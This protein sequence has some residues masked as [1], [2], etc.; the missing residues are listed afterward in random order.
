MTYLAAIVTMACFGLALRVSGVVPA[1]ARAVATSRSAAKLMRDS[2]LNESE[3]E[4]AARR[5][6]LLLLGT[7]LSIS[8][9]TTAALL[10]SV[11][12]LLAFQTGGVVRASAVTAVFSTW[13]GVVLGSAVMGLMFC[14]RTG[15]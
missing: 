7:G 3:K 10:V 6:G 14:V 12:P 2:T 9:R 5:Y 4:R 11:V 13:Q 8:A 15:R 1:A